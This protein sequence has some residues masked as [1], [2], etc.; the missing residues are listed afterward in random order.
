[1]PRGFRD[2]DHATRSDLVDIQAADWGSSGSGLAWWIEVD[3][4]PDS[5]S[6]RVF[7][8]KSVA[9][10]DGKGVFTMPLWLAEEK[11]LA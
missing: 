1:M 3:R 4:G 9:E 5:D 8:P 2:D 10:H 7:L 11:G 6:E